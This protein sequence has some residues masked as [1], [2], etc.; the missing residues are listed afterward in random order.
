[1]FLRAS[2]PIPLAPAGTAQIDAAQQR[3]EFFDRDLKSPRAR[4]APSVPIS[5]E[6]HRRSYLLSRARLGT[7]SASEWKHK[8]YSDFG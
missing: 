6:T 5:V 1:M 3:S 7:T 2:A 8:L 4:F